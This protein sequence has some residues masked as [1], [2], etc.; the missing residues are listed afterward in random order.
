MAEREQAQLVITSTAHRRA[1]SLV[2]SRRAAALADLD[3]PRDV[4]LVEWS[5]VPGTDLAD[6]DGWRAASPHWLARRERL[7]ASKL[8]RA[9]AG[10]GDPEDLDDDPLAAFRSQWL[11]DWSVERAARLVGRDEPLTDAETWAGA[12]DLA[13]APVLGLPLVIAAEDNLGHGAAVGFA[14][15]LPDGR[16]LAWGETCARRAQAGSESHAGGGAVSGEPAAAAVVAAG[17]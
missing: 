13:V 16:I 3:A 12:A 15:R 1:T 11:N 4:L 17:R 8:V 14:Q 5:A 2:P 6:R 10:E 7:V 9:Q